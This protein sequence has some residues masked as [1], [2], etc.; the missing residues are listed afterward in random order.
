MRTVFLVA[1]T[2][3]VAH[4]ASSS[5]VAPSNEDVLAQLQSMQVRGEQMNAM[6]AQ[7]GD[8]KEH[9]VGFQLSIIEKR[10]VAW[11]PMKR[12]S[13]GDVDRETLF[14]AIEARLMEVLAA[15]ERLGISPEEI[16]EHIRERNTRI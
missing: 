5:P 15:G 2:T 10:M 12:S 1:L 4:L 9:T 6:R 11:Q 8:K 14:R 3:I 16:L 13:G 7:L